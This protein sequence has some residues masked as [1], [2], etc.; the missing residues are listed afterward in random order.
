MLLYQKKKNIGTT[1]WHVAN[2]IL[3]VRQLPA[4]AHCPLLPAARCCQL[5]PAAA[6]CCLLLLS[7]GA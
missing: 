5:L 7:P 6:C 3:L 1:L 4:A 2:L